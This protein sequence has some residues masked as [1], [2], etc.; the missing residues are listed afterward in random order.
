MCLGGMGLID[1]TGQN[2]KLVQYHSTVVLYIGI[3]ILAQKYQLNIYILT[4]GQY[5]LDIAKLKNVFRSILNP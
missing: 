1:N 2:S 4:V 5:W 3:M